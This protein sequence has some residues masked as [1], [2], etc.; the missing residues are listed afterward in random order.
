MDRDTILNKED[1][2]KTL[3]AFGAGEADI[4]VGTQMVAKGHDFPNVTLVGILLA[5]M[6]MSVP[7]FRANE[8]SLQLLMQVSGRAGRSKSPGKVLVQT[9]QPEHP[10]FQHLQAEEQMDSY[11]SFLSDE[12]VKR[13]LL[14][15]PPYASLA[16]LR[17]DGLIEDKVEEAARYVARTLN[18]AGAP[19][20]QV[21]GPTPSPISKL[22]GRHRQQILI[23]SESKEVFE[24][25]LHW[26]LQ[27]W[28]KGHCEKNYKTRLLVDVDP[29]QMM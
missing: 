10:V 27:G 4:L 28:T 19:G 18:R 5:D 26:L 6:G 13:K 14:S 17:F 24:R 11:K 3:E 21:L 12:I 8:R 29:V 2:E 25:T 7:D 1:L 23:K 15:Y 20:F 9:F 22:R 16:L